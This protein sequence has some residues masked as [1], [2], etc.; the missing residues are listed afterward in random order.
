MSDPKAVT[1]DIAIAIALVDT[2]LKSLPQ[3]A[4]FE[5]LAAMLGAAVLRLAANV[6]TDVTYS[7]LEGF[8]VKG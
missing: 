7:Q 6:G 2:V 3:T 5:P 8:R 4:A 1:A